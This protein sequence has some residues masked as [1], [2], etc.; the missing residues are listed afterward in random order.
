[1]KFSKVIFFL[2]ALHIAATPFLLNAKVVETSPGVFTNI[3]TEE[4]LAEQNARIEQE[5]KEAEEARVKE[6]NNLLDKKSD[7]ERQD[8]EYD[9]KRYRRLREDRQFDDRRWDQLREQRR[10]DDQRRN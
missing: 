5:K 3:L 1:M 10:R 2:S 6:Y 7:R 4:E 8:K 9:E